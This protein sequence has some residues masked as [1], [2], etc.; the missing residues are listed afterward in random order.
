MTIQMNNMKNSIHLYLLLF[1]LAV[2]MTACPEPERQAAIDSTIRIVN[3]S[4]KDLFYFVD[5]GNYP[6]THIILTYP[7][8]Q[9]SN[10]E[11]YFYISANSFVDRPGPWISEYDRASTSKFMYFLFDKAE[12][13]TLP[14]DSIRKN[15]K[16]LKRWDLSLEEIQAM[17]WTLEYP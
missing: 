2:I 4:D 14:W 5:F 3:E 11:S 6:D 12:V 17:N 7:L 1:S 9:S 16:V 13:D 15:Y 8:F 10:S